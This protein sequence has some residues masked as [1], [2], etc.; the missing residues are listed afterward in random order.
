MKTPLELAIE[1]LKFLKDKADNVIAEICYGM[2]ITICE[3]YLEK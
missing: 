1:D 3:M 2:A